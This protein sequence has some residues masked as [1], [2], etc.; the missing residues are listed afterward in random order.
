MA[1]ETPRRSVAV[2]GAAGFVGRRLLR[3][4]ERAGQPATA[5]FRGAPELSMDGTF[6]TP[7]RSNDLATAGRHH[8]VVNLAYPAAGSPT[9]F[10]EQNQE[11]F[12]TV[13]RLLADGG[14]VIHVSTQ[15]VFGLSGDWPIHLGPVDPRRDEP[16]VE[17]KIE[18]EKHFEEQQRAQGYTLEIVRLGNV[19]GPGSGAWAL[20]LVQKLVTG[21]PIGVR[22]SAGFSNTTDV[23]NAVSYLTHLVQL[24]RHPGASY[25][26]LAEFSAVPWQRWVEGI[27][28]ELGVD[29][30]Y[31]EPEAIEMADGV[32]EEIAGTLAPMTPRNLYQS[33]ARQRMSGSWT[34]SALR[35]LPK[36]VFESLKGPKLVF[37]GAHPLDRAERTFL[38]IMSSRQEFKSHLAPDWRPP[39]TE[40]ESLESVLDWLRTG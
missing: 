10:P 19:W 7:L 17:A 4:L 22:G 27:A 26:H 8:V 9:S 14:R 24:D 35:L 5:V 32:V 6:H 3:A 11:I 13:A 21:R 15:A 18:A 34:R 29:P 25:H 28:R 36:S 12:R 2:V 20:P 23:A 40:T 16:Y 39:I 37:A 30:V 38:A 31:V 33:M 1:N